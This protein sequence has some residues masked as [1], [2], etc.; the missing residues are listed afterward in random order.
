M[1]HKFI[2]IPVFGILIVFLFSCHHRQGKGVTLDDC[3]VVA[4][5]AGSLT[6]LDIS[7]VKDTVYVPLSTFL[8]DFE[9]IRLENS[10]EALIGL[11]MAVAVSKHYIGVFCVQTRA[12]KLF[13]Q[14]GDYIRNISSVGQGPD[15]FLA[16][17]DSYIDEENNRIYLLPYRATKLLVFDIEGN[18]QQHIRLPFPVHK[19]RFRIDS[20]KKELIMTAMPFSDTPFVVWRQDFD[21][22]ILQGIEAGHFV[23]EPGDYANEVNESQNTTF[24]DFSLLYWMPRADSLYHYDEVK[25]VLD[26]TFTVSWKDVIIRHGYSELPHHFFVDLVLQSAPPN[27]TSMP[28]PPLIIVNKNN[29]RG[30]YAK[31]KFDMLGDIDGPSELFFNRGYFYAVMF[32]YELKEQLENALSK[33][34]NLT[35]AM[36]EKLEQLNSSLTED[37]NNVFFIGK[38]KED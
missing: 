7:S 36:K 29:L 33:P 15:E 23:I 17:Y 16:L 12:Y 5:K 26:P 31:I 34:E 6:V 1:K 25:N 20:E 19:G 28:Q 37:D 8:S 32:T 18:A 38:L 13:N 3:P 10:D 35:L 30:S 4:H 2:S 22:N 27:S 24:M 11:T 9:M 21:G 14:Q